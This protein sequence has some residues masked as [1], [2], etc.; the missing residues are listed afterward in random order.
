[1]KVF[2]CGGGDGK[3]VLPAYLRLNEIIDPTKP[4]LYIPLAMHSSCYDAC[5]QWINKELS[6][7][8]LPFIKTVRSA[9]ELAC[10]NLG[11]YSM[12]FIGGGNTFRLLKELKE[13]GAYEAIQTFI[14]HN[15]IVFGSSA[16]AIIFGKN[17]DAC[18]LE[19]TNDVNLFD[20][21]GFDLLKGIS[22][23]CHF[24]NQSPQKDA[25]T[26]SYLRKLSQNAPAI[27]LPEDVTLFLNDERIETLGDSPFYFFNEGVMSVRSHL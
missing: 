25:Q 26:K 3:Q 12:L 4:C 8:N 16:G 2:L 11:N 18:R 20:T 9:R 10:E 24:T 21:N 22:L 15:G 5:T 19:D 6:I 23:V 7:L 17:L 13:S 27:A 14:Q 1:M